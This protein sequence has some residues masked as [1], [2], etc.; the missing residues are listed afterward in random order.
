VGVRLSAVALLMCASL[1]EGA[2]GSAFFKT[3]GTNILDQS[4]SNFFMRGQALNGWLIPEA[5]QLRLTSV[6]W[7]HM[8]SGSTVES[9]ILNL[10]GTNSAL[11]Q[12]FWDTYRS[13]Y[14]TMADLALLKAEG[15][16]TI[17]LP[18]NYRLVQPYATTGVW[19]NA[20]FQVLS[21]AIAW[22]KSN[23]LAVILDMHC[24]PGGQSGDSPADP[25]YT[26][27]VYDTNVANWIEK[28]VG[29]LWETNAAYTT[30]TGRTPAWNRQRT[31]DIWREIAKRFKNEK[32]ILGYE[33]INEPFLPAGVNWPVLRELMT[34]I[35]AAVRAED[36]N[37]IIFVE[38]NYF[39]G[40]FEG[41]FPKWDSNVVYMFHRYWSTATTANIS[42][43]LG[44][45][46][47]NNVPVVMGETGENSNPW[48]Y[49]FK[50]VLESNGVGWCWWGWK[51]VDS[52]AGSYSAKITPDYQYVIDN[53]RDSNVDSTRIFK[54]LMELATNLQTSLCREEPGYFPA[55]RDPQFDTLRKP[56]ATL[57]APGFIPASDYDVG[58]DGTAY[59]DT[60]TKQE[61]GAGGAAWNS[62]WAY[63]ND[64]V[65]VFST[66][67][68]LGNG[69]KIGDISATE[70]YRY[71]VV[72]PVTTRCEIVARL[73]SPTN[74]GRIRIKLNGVNLTPNTTVPVTGNYE[75]WTNLSLGV[76][77]IP[78]RTNLIEVSVS[79]G[80]YDFAS[81]S[82]NPTNRITRDLG[83]HNNTA[84]NVAVEQV[85]GTNAFGSFLQ[86]NYATTTTTFFVLGAH[87]SICPRFDETG[88]V[89]IKISYF[90]YVS[91]AWY[92]LFVPMSNVAEVVL[93][94]NSAFH[95]L[96]ASG[97]ATVDVY[98]FDWDQPR[99][100]SGEPLTS[101][102]VVYYAPYFRT[103]SG[104][105]ETARL[106]LA[107]RSAQFTNSYPVKPQ[108]FATNFLDTDYSYTNLFPSLPVAAAPVCSPNGGT[109]TNS[110]NVTI[111]SV[112]TGA[113]NYYTIDGS[114]PTTNSPSATNNA[115]ITL[116]QPYANSIRS[117]A[118]AGGYQDSTI[119][120]SAAFS[121]VAM[122]VASAP[123]CSPNGG[124]FTNSVNVT[125]SS[126]TAGATNYYTTDGSTPTTNSASITNNGIITLS[127]PYANSVRSFAQ[128]A[129]Y[130]ASTASTSAAFNVVA[131]E[132]S[133]EDGIVD[134]WEQLQFGNL[135]QGGTNDPDGDGVSNFDEFIADTQPTNS[136]SY[137]WQAISAVTPITTT[138]SVTPSS[139]GRVYS[140]WAQTNLMSL[141]AWWDCGVS[142]AGNGA[143]LYL[144][145]TNS[146][147]SAHYGVRVRLP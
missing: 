5:Y 136:A 82:F 67:G 66:T 12:T 3:S 60:R 119:S 75:S 24:A 65:D 22:C 26:Y 52:I 128:A 103:F 108:L 79:A 46:S 71:S 115:I 19:D 33:L 144:T 113:V 36:T 73:A 2:G 25:E 15:F 105:T 8:G 114:T 145:V 40:T 51:K 97:A 147:D 100:A 72:A 83:Y 14:V 39:S 102:V 122:P 18:F 101:N 10:L 121:V 55:L 132:D 84:T 62:G 32:Q 16:N 117:F 98:R 47:S 116:S 41:L 6:H 48:F 139:T 107:N 30:A 59:H 111:A 70:Y 44:A 20:G 140:A 42:T 134:T 17:R 68:G 86:V 56:Y 50:N 124:T 92:D 91:N 120:T 35:T 38:G 125:I 146:S 77:T 74:T 141:S 123:V 110:V 106:Y 78:Q 57:T 90:N 143:T 58:D 133:D 87:P 109:Y 21:N 142:S 96:P 80:N 1:A 129:G 64:G 45:R 54:G 69:Y 95:G 53:F 138:L 99:G 81:L 131:A 118:K 104:T 89:A 43:F 37:H 28:G 93:A 88:Q 126:A 94:T 130:Q 31:V 63:R 7:R 112:T 61:D 127:Q 85:P 9:N 29:C 49:Q 135:D 137:L 4:G 11:A 13:N 76:W 27:W 23:D 34:N